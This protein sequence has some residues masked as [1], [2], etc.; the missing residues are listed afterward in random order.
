MPCITYSKFVFFKTILIFIYMMN[1]YWEFSGRVLDSRPRGSGF[2]PLW[3]H[4]VVV[5]E[6]DTFILALY[7]FNPGIPVSV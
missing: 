1:L 7:W 6:Q 3:Y 2:E 4:C 5:V